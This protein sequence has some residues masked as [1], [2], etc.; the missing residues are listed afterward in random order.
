[1]HFQLSLIEPAT[2][3]MPGVVAAAQH[4]DALRDYPDPRMVV[5]Q[6]YEGDWFE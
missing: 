3:D 5:G 6:L 1:M 4:A 2:H